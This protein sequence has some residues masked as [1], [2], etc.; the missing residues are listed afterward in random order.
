MTRVIDACGDQCE[1]I[2]VP[3][4]GQRLDK[5][6]G[7]WVL[8]RAG[9]RVL[10]PGGLALT[11]RMIDAL[12]ISS[13]D[14]V[15]EFAPGTGVTA[16]RVL[17]RKPFQYWG[18]ER[19]PLAAARLESLLRRDAAQIV[20]APAEHSGLPEAC[21]SV[22]Y[23][24]AM[25]SMQTPN[26]R[27]AS[28]LKY[29]GFSLRAGGTGFTSYAFGPT[30]YRRPYDERSKQRCRR[31]FTSECSHSVRLNRRIYWSSKDSR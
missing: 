27:S 22:V 26:R 10:R 3:G 31:R 20:E 21:A 7:H 17:R 14:R 15:V 18:V 23:G 25:L 11:R 2:Q 28:F 5:M 24:E 9:K 16:R 4:P 6:Q 1:S 19:D 30:E 12:S 29:G 8:A 13:D